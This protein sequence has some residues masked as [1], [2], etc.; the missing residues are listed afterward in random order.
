MIEKRP[1]HASYIDGLRA[2]AVLSVI[3]FH[4]NANW[5]PGGFAGVDVFFVISGFVVAISV[6]EIGTTSLTR[7]LT[8]FYARRLVRIAPALVACLFVTFV[9]SALLIPQAWL[10]DA[11][12]KTGL[13]AF[14]GLS[15]FVLAAN[16]GNYFSPVVE[17]NPFTH[18]WSLAVE[19][20]FY[21]AFPWLFILWLRSRRVA[22]IGLFA[23]ALT[24]SLI[25]SA[26]LGRTDQ[27]QAFYMIWCR[28]WQLGAGV[29]LF[30]IMHI[31]GHSFN[32]RSPYLARCG[33]VADL[34]LLVLAVGLIVARPDAAPFPAGILPV[35][36]TAMILGNLHGREGGVSH[37]L[38]T[39]QAMVFL[40]RISYSLYLWH[41]PVFVL[42][43][44]TVGLESHVWQIAALVITTVIAILSY[45]LVEQP[46][47]QAARRT[48]KRR[49][50]AAGA[51][52]VFS[53]C[54]LSGAISYAQPRISLSTV[55]RNMDVWY[56]EGPRTPHAT[57]G[58]SV[59]D[60]SKRSFNGGL[61]WINARSQCDAAV[62]FPH[63]VFVLG[64]SH[65]LAYTG[66]LKQFAIRTGAKVYVY[67]KP[68]CPFISLLPTPG[69]EVS[70]RAFGDAAVADMLPHIKP[71]DVVF[72]ASLRLP[73]MVDQWAFF[74]VDSA[75]HAMFG[76][77]AEQNR[78]K[79][80]EKAIPV[81]KKIAARG[82][83]VVFEAPTP[84][85]ESIP[86][87]CAD[88]FNRENPICAQ[89]MSVPHSLI[90][91]LRAPVLASYKQMEAAIP[92]LSVWDP[93]TVLCPGSECQA[94]RGDKPLL[95]DG[96]HLSY[97]SNMLLLPSFSTFVSEDHLLQLH[98]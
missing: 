58:C 93:M 87:R 26:R 35:A 3:A 49:L 38:L 59:G 31:R 4:L 28:F 50:I 90:D 66:M 51:I 74:G 21:F 29:L 64:D 94:Y 34:G 24:A 67:N 61:F 8:Y 10:S 72:L 78:Q 97:F 27:T 89:G 48:K 86:Y 14:L 85:L 84:M 44:W 52:L 37:M 30:Q 22:S 5:L 60:S 96:D 42:F 88:W 1:F 83:R 19:E 79:D 9:A 41:W 54:V 25:C 45:Y 77:D 40:G 13:S 12:N 98:F 65:A 6:S 20:Q 75:K 55:S 36:G 57:N 70:C 15:N 32:E 18:T 46:P 47:R 39:N 80:V 53:G 23:V 43:R 63:N 62:T 81:L 7:F 92:N 11:N 33:V 91:D 69:R 56:P 68:G 73:R 82:A 17:F 71:G 95:F 2:I 76:P 16:T